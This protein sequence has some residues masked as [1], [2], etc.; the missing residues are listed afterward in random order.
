VSIELEGA[1]PYTLESDGSADGGYAAAFAAQLHDFLE[2]VRGRGAPG[3][4]G[5]DGVAVLEVV[6]ACYAAREPLAERW[7]TET[8]PL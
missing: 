3:A 8:L 4:S 6:D 1:E 2:A 5:A 7:V